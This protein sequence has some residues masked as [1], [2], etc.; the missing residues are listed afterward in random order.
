MET[1]A[2]PVLQVEEPLP[3]LC[4]AGTSLLAQQY[5]RIHLAFIP[6]EKELPNRLWST[7]PLAMAASAMQKNAAEALFF[8]HVRLRRQVPFA[9]GH[10]PLASR[11]LTVSDHKVSSP[12]VWLLSL[13]D[14]LV[15]VRST[16]KS[17]VSG[18]LVTYFLWLLV[19]IP[20][21]R[22]YLYRW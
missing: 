15:D 4:S 2:A 17:V 11:A 18:R 16:R 6:S 7:N 8:S 22:H 19:G 9:P 20:V 1:F 21:C 10:A 13:W 14:I 5:H 12:D 3:D